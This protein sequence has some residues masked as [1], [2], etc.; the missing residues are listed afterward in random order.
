L[1]LV[2]E[3]LSS[4]GLFRERAVAVVAPGGAEDVLRRFVAHLVRD[5]GVG[6]V[7]AGNYCRWV[8][9][10]VEGLTGPGGAVDWGLASADTVDA[11]VAG[12]ARGAKPG[13]ARM[14]VCSMRALLRWAHAN[15]WVV[16]RLDM[17][18][19]SAS[20]RRPEP[21]RVVTAAEV[22]R[23]VGSLGRDSEIGLRDRAVLVLLARLGCRAGE[24][25]G[26]GLDDVDWRAGTVTVRGKGRE[27]TL[28]LPADVGEAVAEWLKARRVWAGRWL[29]A[30]VLAPFGPLTPARVSGI[31]ADRAEAAGLGRFNAHRLR[32]A[33]AG[34]VLD[35]GGS[36]EEVSRLLGHSRLATSALYAQ[37]GGVALAGLVEPWPQGGAS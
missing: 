30:S 22:D 19:M 3:Y 8:R 27:L 13:S 32:H 36:L 2:E 9:P 6:G 11:F 35:G 25:A 34:R 37:A 15:G 14:V 10:F 7:S 4:L 12:R 21:G 20:P 16:T 29:F 28:P 1:R 18:V 5:R 17:A 26:L 33:A 24:V 23:L 31:V